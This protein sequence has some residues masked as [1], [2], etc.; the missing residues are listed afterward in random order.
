MLFRMKDQEAFFFLEKQ[1]QLSNS[2]NL[3]LQINKKPQ[4]SNKYVTLKQKA[5]KT[6]KEVK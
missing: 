2:T 6:Y 4:A 3:N 5:T 1:L